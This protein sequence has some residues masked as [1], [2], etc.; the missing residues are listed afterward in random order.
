MIRISIQD[1]KLKSDFI[2]SDISQRQSIF[3]ELLRR[4]Q[5]YLADYERYIERPNDKNRQ[6]IID[7]WK[8][9][10]PLNPDIPFKKDRHFTWGLI[11]YTSCPAVVREVKAEKLTLEVNLNFSEKKILKA[12]SEIIKQTKKEADNNPVYLLEGVFNKW[13]D[14]EYYARLCFVF[15]HKQAGLKGKAII[16]KARKNKITGINSE[17]NIYNNLDTFKKLQQKISKI[18]SL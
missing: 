4:N 1:G 18:P 16:D 7:R 11:N 15:D 3:W 14:Q 8:L 9:T 17:Q 10:T 12:I 6:R 5:D 13:Q 2:G